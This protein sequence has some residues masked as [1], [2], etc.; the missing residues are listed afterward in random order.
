[1]S[2]DA[3]ILAA[4]K[5]TRMPSPRPKVLQTLLGETMLALVTSTLNAMPRVKGIF[6]MVGCEAAMVSAEADAVAARLGRKAYCIEQKEQKGTGHA[7]MTAMPHLEGEGRLLVV[8]GDAPL[9][10]S[11]VLDR[12]LDGAEGADAGLI[13]LHGGQI[14]DAAALQKIVNFLHSCYLLFLL[15]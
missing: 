13:P 10:T 8:N 14:V 5:G 15:I 12:F 3:L 4:G 11:E 2:I 1:M 7:L 6:T 9:L